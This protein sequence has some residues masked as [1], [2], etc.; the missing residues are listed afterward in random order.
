VT[1]NARVRV[2][3]ALKPVGPGKT[4]VRVLGGIATQVDLA[5]GPVLPLA[6]AA[7]Q[8]E[9]KGYVTELKARLADML[10]ADGAPS[11]A[12]RSAS[13]AASR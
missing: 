2:A 6:Q 11:G 7:G 13:A 5:G 10:T 12:P 8:K 9:C 3:V 4:E 1:G